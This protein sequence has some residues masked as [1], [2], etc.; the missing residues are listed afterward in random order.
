MRG[1][2][3]FEAYWD[4]PGV[5]QI[6]LNQ[7][8]YNGQTATLTLVSEKAG[9]SSQALSFERIAETKDY[10]AYL[11][12]LPDLDFDGRYR[13]EDDRGL[14]VPLW[15]GRVVESEAFDL[16]YAT[17]GFLGAS[18]IAKQ[19]DHS[20]EGFE[21]RFGLWAPTADQVYLKIYAVDEGAKAEEF[22]IHPMERAT[23][24]R[25]CL[26]L[27][28]EVLPI[29]GKAP[30]RWLAY[31][32]LVCVNGQC[33]EATDPYAFSTLPN[34]EASVVIENLSV[35]PHR[36][37]PLVSV[38]D[39][40]HPKINAEGL[41]AISALSAAIYEV[42]VRDFTQG[43]TG[44]VDKPGT[45]EAMAIPGL[46]V[47]GMPV[48]RDYLKSLGITHV[49]LLPVYDFGS[50]DE[51]KPRARYNWG[52]DPIQYFCPEGSLSDNPLDPVARVLGLKRLISALHEDGLGVVMDVVYNHMF[53]RDTSA[54]ELVVP[55]YYFRVDAE[56]KASNGSFCGNDLDS[57]RRML[58]RLILDATRHWMVNYDFDGFR[59]DLMGIL[60]KETMRGVQQLVVGIKP[61]G[62]VYGEG[63]NMPTALPDE[64]KAIMQHPDALKGI[65]FFNDRFRDFYK[66]PTMTERA[67]VKGLLTGLSRGRGAWLEDSGFRDLFVSGDLSQSIQYMECH[68][69]HT[70]WDKLVLSVP[71][72]S[73]KARRQLQ[74][75]LNAFVALSFG[76]PFFHCGQEWYRTKG[77]DHNS[78]RSGDLVNAVDWS[79]VAAGADGARALAAALDLRRQF[80][81]FTVRDLEQVLAKTQRRVLKSG[82][83]VITVAGDFELYVNPTGK[84][85]TL[86]AVTAPWI[87]ATELEEPT[88]AVGLHGL[89]KMLPPFS[90]RVL[91]R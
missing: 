14:S 88:D 69:N 52:Y 76:V 85:A 82:V 73:V 56:G 40:N 54:L 21:A 90:L 91:R 33:R 72:L 79:A 36:A 58:R 19:G 11:A 5:A 63:W 32:Y 30:Y 53:D 83:L 84:V 24:G 41:G 62:L 45:Y 87:F 75:T 46:M 26:M 7:A 22:G 1:M 77:G 2:R 51:R 43:L 57:T 50:V 38:S 6:Y 81:V 10:T 39:V 4:G 48:G 35:L 25:W 16:R 8:Y 31:R 15:F 60:D 28:G 64:V 66:G 34:Q 78:Y 71:D 67:A 70:L 29:S 12:Y 13:I 49:Q 3:T 44:L 65:G 55:G 47:N 9:E 18:L 17:E 59:F 42:S 68:D 89:T 20:A 61:Q 23:D 86:P 80:S 37:D 27:T 74:R